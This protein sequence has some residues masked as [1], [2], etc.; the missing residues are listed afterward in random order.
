MVASLAELSYSKK[1]LWLDLREDSEVEEVARIQNMKP[2]EE[3][4]I[5]FQR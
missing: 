5:L 3:F 2:W 4:G 1:L